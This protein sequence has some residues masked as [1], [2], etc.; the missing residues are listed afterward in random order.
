MVAWSRREVLFAGLGVAALAAGTRQV[1]PVAY[2]A[3]PAPA[4]AALA[5]LEQRYDALVGLFALDL[6][7]GRSLARRDDDPFAMCS[8]FKTYAAGSVLQRAQRNEL[9]LDQQV[10][11]DPAEL[12]ANSPVTEANAGSSMTL[13]ALCV[14]ALQRSDNTAANLLLQTIGG[15]PAIT[16]F[17]RSIGDNRS[18]LDRWE[19]ELN[20]ALPGDPRD[21]SSPR[22]LGGG[23]RAL[24]T[25]DVLDETHRA[26]LETWMRGNTTSEKSLRAGLPPGWTSADKTGA[27]D[28]GS[29]NAVGI[30]FAPDGRRLLLS[31]MT[32]SRSTNPDAPWLQPLIAEVTALAVTE[33]M[34]DAR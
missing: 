27:G 5:A 8:T 12:V 33:L 20:S 21:T 7:S 15:P 14:A 2:A 26:Q 23:Y 22:A 4:D 24:L 30:A 10:F 18:R 3:P 6:D 25:G 32:R 11:V 13:A 16:E 9:R 19:T 31:V 29:T 34:P 1:M 28:Y 17:A